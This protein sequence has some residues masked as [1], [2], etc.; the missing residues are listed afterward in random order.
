MLERFHP[1]HYYDSIFEIPYKELKERRIEALI[2][3]VDN[4]L[5]EYHMRRP[6]EKTFNL[7]VRLKKMGFKVALLTNNGRSRLSRFNETLQLPAYHKGLK[8]FVGK[9]KKAMKDLIVNPEHT[10][11][12]GD[13]VL[14]DIW[15]GKRLKITTILV[16]PISQKDVWTVYIKRGLERKIVKSYVKKVDES[17]SR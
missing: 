11:I 4:T 8:P 17:R 13:Q 15:C 14:T 6:P 16:K 3:D 7:L 12:I 2:F 5:V 9:A 1:D 10:A